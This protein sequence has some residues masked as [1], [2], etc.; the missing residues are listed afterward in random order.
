[1]FVD[2][3]NRNRAQPWC[4]SAVFVILVLDMPCNNCRCHH[5]AICC[6]RHR[7]A[8]HYASSYI[9][10]AAHSIVLHGLGWSSI[11]DMVVATLSSSEP[12]LAFARRSQSHC[13]ADYPEISSFFSSVFHLR[14]GRLE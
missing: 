14:F 2:R 6:T 8:H 9:L 4:P 13:A 11:I 7:H 3:K 12:L 5:C 10:V 1:M